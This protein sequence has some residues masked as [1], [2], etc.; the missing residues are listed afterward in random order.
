MIIKDQKDID[1]LKKS[2]AM[3]AY[4]RDGIKDYLRSGMSTLEADEYAGKLFKETGFISAPKELYDFP[5]NT[6]LSVNSCVAH[7][8][9]S[10]KIVLKDGDS[11]NI[12][13][14]GSY[15]GYYTDSGISIVIGRN[16]QREAA[17]NCA[18]DMFF[19]GITK[20]KAN[21][22][23]KDM[24]MEMEATCKENGFVPIKKLSGH[25]IGNTLHEKPR[26][27]HCHHMVWDRRRFANNMVV[28]IET[29]VS[30]TSGTVV[31]GNDGWSWIGVGGAVVAQ[32]EHTL[33]VTEDEPII[34][35]V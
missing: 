34:I 1:G 3:C 27:I 30:S 10:K 32:Y 22:L 13:V 17:C 20:I 29:F 18:K 8:I 31:V 19:N 14:C 16:S 15:D 24:G 7:G 26:H 28:A 33:I 4:I 35:T 9:P 25:G 21:A 2:G 6:C 5:G 23:F 12:D 11:I